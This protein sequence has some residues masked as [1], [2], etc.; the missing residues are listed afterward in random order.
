VE[1][2]DLSHTDDAYTNFGVQ[3]SFLLNIHG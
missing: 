1:L 3:F 2:P